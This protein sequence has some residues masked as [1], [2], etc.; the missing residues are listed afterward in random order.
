MPETVTPA[1]LENQ[2]DVVRNELRQRIE[3]TPF[4]RINAPLQ[5]H[6][7]AAGHPYTHDALG[8]REEI[9]AVTLTE[10]LA[11]FRRYYT[12]DNFSLVLAGD[13]DRAQVTVDCA[14]FRRVRTCRV[15]DGRR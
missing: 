15:R 14:V 13:F 7:F 5:A 9:A 8:S 10:A 3:N 2:K 12:A 1:K 4:A 11:F 6:T